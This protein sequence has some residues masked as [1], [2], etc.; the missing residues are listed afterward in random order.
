MLLDT[1]LTLSRVLK[2]LAFLAL[3]ITISYIIICE[4]SGL[5][6]QQWNDRGQGIF[7]GLFAGPFV[8]ALLFSTSDETY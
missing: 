8:L 7:M 2:Y 1:A 6:W 5:H 3:I 4:V